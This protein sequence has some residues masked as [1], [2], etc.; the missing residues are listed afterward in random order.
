M[1]LNAELL[2]GQTLTVGVTPQQGGLGLANPKLID[3]GNPWN[4]VIALRIAKTGTGHMP[5]I[6]PREV[7]VKGLK[8]IEDWIARMGN[9]VSSADELLPKEWTEDVLREKLTTV[10]GAMQVLRAVDDDLLKEPLRQTALSIAWKSPQVTVRDLFDRF[11]P[12]DQ[13][14]RTLGANI[15]AA[16][17]LA[18]KGDAVRGSQVLSLQ[19]K[20]ATCFA[21]HFLDGTGRDFGPDLSKIGGRLN[22]AQILESIAQP[23]KV[24]ALG[25]AAV[26]VEMKD[27]SVQTGFMIKEEAQALFLKTATAQ[28]LTLKKDEISKQTKLSTS[29]MPE[30]LLQ[31]LT[32]QE[33]ADVIAFLELHR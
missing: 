9:K 17:I 2:L 6:G 19:G 31:S 14:E 23:S 33:V 29:L 3:A 10:E 12:E 26:T 18:L 5:I 20:L 11:K 15:N 25:F 1:M 8:L 27:G 4:S 21:C 30:G 24:I 16:E 22:R 7:D 28:T 32:A 13:R